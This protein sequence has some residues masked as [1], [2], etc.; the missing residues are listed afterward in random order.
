MDAATLQKRINS[1]YGKAATRI[2]Y[3]CD[4]Y[5]P[6]APTTVLVAANLLRLPPINVSF[7]V[8]G[9]KYNY[10][11]PGTHTDTLWLG[12]L[13]PTLYN[14][15][16]YFFNTQD[17]TFFLAAKQSELPTLFVK[18]DTVFKVLRPSGSSSAGISGYSGATTATETAVLTGWPGALTLE[19]KGRS[20]GAN[21]PMD[22]QNSFFVVFLPILAGVDIRSSDILIDS[23]GRRYIVVASDKSALG[24]RMFVQNAVT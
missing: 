15:G 7:T 13:D 11:K 10:Y 20:S 21:L 19:S 17:G 5:R 3:T 9:S 22:E 1:G 24:W 8:N 18:C 16:D 23:D 2:G 4:V 14:V 6:T 12:I